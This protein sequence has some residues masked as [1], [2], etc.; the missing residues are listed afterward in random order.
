[1]K[2]EATKVCDLIGAKIDAISLAT[3]TGYKGHPTP[4]LSFFR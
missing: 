1:M 2:K 3:I 4:F